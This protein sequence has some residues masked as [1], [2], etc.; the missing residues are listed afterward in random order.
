MSE[1]QGDDTP[2]SPV[3][4]RSFTWIT[5][6]LAILI[7][8]AICITFLRYR[9][10]NAQRALHGMHAL[11]RDLEALGPNRIRRPQ[12]A[13]WQWTGVEPHGRV[14]RIGIG[15]GSREEGLNELGEAPPA[16]TPPRK[17]SSGAVE[18]HETVAS[19]STVQP[20][21][22]PTSELRPAVIAQT[23]NSVNPPAYGE[24]ARNHEM[25]SVGRGSPSRPTPAHLPSL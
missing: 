6:P 3:E 23:D 1:S 13:R 25:A 14:R 22:H 17:T 18:L 5:V 10:R 4:D 16:Y 8:A 11:E 15:V 2:G 12:N 24:A 19:V 7:A 21:A 9:R 20:T